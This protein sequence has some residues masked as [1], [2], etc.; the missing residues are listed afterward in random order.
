M[1][2]TKG[3]TVLLLWYLRKARDATKGKGQEKKSSIRMITATFGVSFQCQ[4]HYLIIEMIIDSGFPIPVIS[5]NVCMYV[6]CIY[7]CICTYRAHRSDSYTP[8]VLLSYLCT[9]VVA[10]YSDI[11]IL[12]DAHV[13]HASSNFTISF[14]MVSS[15]TPTRCIDRIS[16]NA[17]NRIEHVSDLVPTPV[18]AED[19]GWVVFA[20]NVTENISS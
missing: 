3:W 12:P 11:V 6:T 15:F 1:L 4:Y 18:F 20:I 9:Y 13:K 8:H 2:D 19:V 17:E 16:G 14:V 10:N 7:I 5:L